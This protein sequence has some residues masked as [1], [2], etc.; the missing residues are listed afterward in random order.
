[1]PFLSWNE[2]R[3]H[4]PSDEGNNPKILAFEMRR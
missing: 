2:L 3:E 4:A 1:M